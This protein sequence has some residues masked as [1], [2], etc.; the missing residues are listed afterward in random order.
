MTTPSQIATLKHEALTF[1]R[2]AQ[3]RRMERASPVQKS[4]NGNPVLERRVPKAWG[5]GPHRVWAPTINL[6]D[7][8]EIASW[9][10]SNAPK[11]LKPGGLDFM[12]Q[13]FHGL[14]L[15][16]GTTIHAR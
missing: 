14:T 1:L 6:A 5:E 10:Q 16:D 15:K 4:V 2:E 11:G 8:R 12:D 9:L 3:E 7:F 13:A